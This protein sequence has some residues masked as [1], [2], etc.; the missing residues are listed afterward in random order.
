MKTL[1]EHGRL[2][3]IHKQKDGVL[4]RRD[5]V[6]KRIHLLMWNE[7]NRFIRCKCGRLVRI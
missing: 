1:K 4:I 2:I 3:V 6:C 7:G 5:C